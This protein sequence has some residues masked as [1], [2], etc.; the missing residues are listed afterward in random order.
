MEWARQNKFVITWYEIVIANVMHHHFNIHDSGLCK[1]RPN[2]LW[3]WSQ[4]N[5]SNTWSAMEKI[6]KQIN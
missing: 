3:A 5:N 4:G 6:N 2:G 1:E